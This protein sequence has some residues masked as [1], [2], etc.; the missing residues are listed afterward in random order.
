MR[1]WISICVLIASLEAGAGARQV[2][3]AEQ[4]P[5]SEP[6]PPAKSDDPGRPVLRHGGPA[7][8]HADSGPAKSEA[9]IPKPI[10][11]LPREEGTTV[12]GKREE[13]DTGAA[14]GG[15]QPARR[16]VVGDPLIAKAR[17]MV[18][19]FVDNL[20]NFVCDQVTRRYASHKIETNWKYKDRL[21]VELL[22]SSGK[23]DYRNVRHNGKPLKKGS[24]EDSGQWSTGEFGSLLAA[25]F[26]P[27]TNAKFKF[28]STS[29][30]A[31][32]E[33]KVYDYSVPKTE[34]HWEIRMGSSVKPSY[35]G[36]VWI[37]PGSGR[38]L[39]I[40]M[41]TK[42]LPAGYP[43]DKVETIVDYNWVTIGGT[44]Y[45][46]PVKSDNLS[47]QTGT[48]DCSKNEIEFK[49]YRKFA[50]E[51]NILAVE[52]DI[53]FPEEDVQKPKKPAGKLDPPQ[54]T[55][56]QPDDKKQQD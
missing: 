16:A 2:P 40:E 38:V 37:D 18:F 23:E 31:G 26:H 21:E 25:L 46:M 6:A 14:A 3:A 8:K 41:G 30:A 54:I 45:L 28:R 36:A 49:N 10:R 15:T 48:F 35:S 51:S 1:R 7:Q 32:I 17:E 9:N 42:S 5:A 11:D 56:K 34:S 27:Q 13:R 47:C 19:D 24:P 22:Y 39:R 29:T 44:K 55:V 33:A 12:P 4:K 20:P 43:A 53:S 52:S 50:V